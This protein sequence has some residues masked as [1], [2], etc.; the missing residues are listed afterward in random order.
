MS[1]KGMR[2]TSDYVDW[3]EKEKLISLLSRDGDLVFA[4]LLKVGTYFGLRIG[5]LIK[6]KWEDV[7]NKDTLDLIEGK[8]KKFKSIAIHKE[9]KE[10]LEEH[11]VLEGA[12][13]NQYLFANKQTG[14]PYTIQHINYQLKL[15][16]K[17]HN[18][19]NG[20]RIS[21]HSIRKIFARRIASLNNFS[22]RSLIY[23]SD[24]LNHQ[25]IKTTRIYLGIRSSEIK[26][27]YLNLS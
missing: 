15:L 10:L 12:L 25:D 5:D 17:K 24:I 23:I 3:L 8:T 13:M 21:T 1:I 6:L 20:L 7:M 18:I 16:F 11:F 22:D 2:T 27:I 9:V 4:R 14:K 26:D 19:G